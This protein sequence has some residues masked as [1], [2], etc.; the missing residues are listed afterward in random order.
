MVNLTPEQIEQLKKLDNVDIYVEF[1]KTIEDLYIVDVVKE[2]IKQRGG[3]LVNISKGKAGDVIRK[4]KKNNS[5]QIDK[6]L[7]DAGT[8]LSFT[9]YCTSINIGEN[10][11]TFTVENIWPTSQF[12]TE[13]DE[14]FEKC[15][16]ITPPLPKERNI[17]FEIF[18][19]NYR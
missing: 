3:T 6:Y 2:L 10:S 16:G 19:R 7:K 12:D 11:I 17:D 5:I 13:Q 4:F 8:P 9:F 1:S 14:I 15:F 18:R